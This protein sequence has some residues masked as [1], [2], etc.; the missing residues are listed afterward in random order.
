MVSQDLICDVLAVL[1]NDHHYG[2]NPISEE[3][4]VRFADGG[5]DRD[6]VREAVESTVSLPFIEMVGTDYIR[7]DNSRFDGLVQYLY[8]NCNWDIFTLKIRIHHFEGWDEIDL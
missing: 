5:S 1:A 6:K 3:A 4:L 7:I 2:T 8:D